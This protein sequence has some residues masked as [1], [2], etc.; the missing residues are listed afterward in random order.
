M[1]Q[2]L[3]TANEPLVSRETDGAVVRLLLNC[4]Q[5]RNALSRRMLQSLRDELAELAPRREIKV[6]VLAAA[7]PVFSAGHDLAELSAASPAELE[8]I[9]ALCTEVMEAVRLGPQIVVAEVQGLA[10]A[11]GCQLAATCDLIVAADTASFATPGVKIGLF[12]ST[13][14]VALSRAVPAKKALEMLV[15]GTPLSAAEA[16]DCGLVNRVVAAGELTAAT[17][18]LAQQIAAASGETLR[19][20]K[21]A[22]YEQLALDRP[23]AYATAG[24]TMVCNAQTTDAQEGMRAFLEKRPPRW[25]S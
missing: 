20:G 3:S 7:G 5:R 4:P 6:V 13:P 12:C 11:A 14:A 16:H 18:A 9:F 1:S 10:T 2:T 19:I 8:A 25:T 17:R 24:C 21:R 22:F 23:Q 15:T